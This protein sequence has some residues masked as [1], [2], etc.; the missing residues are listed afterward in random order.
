MFAT[1][2]VPNL[3]AISVPRTNCPCKKSSE[4]CAFDFVSDRVLCAFNFV[5]DRV[6]WILCMCVPARRS[7]GCRPGGGACGGR[8]GRRWRWRRRWRTC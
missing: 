3:T 6:E 1:P 8:G 7:F 4:F 2:A 5:C